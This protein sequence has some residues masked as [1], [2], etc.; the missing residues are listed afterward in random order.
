MPPVVARDAEVF[1]GASPA[2]H[3]YERFALPKG[4][5]R[6][7][8]TGPGVRGQDC[9][10]PVRVIGN[11]KGRDVAAQRPFG[12]FLGCERQSA[13]LRVQSI[14]TDE[15]IKPLQLAVRKANRYATAILFDIPD[16][17]AE[18]DRNAI[19]R[20][21]YRRG[22]VVPGNAEQTTSKISANRSI[23]PMRSATS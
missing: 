1:P 21:Q 16:G 22:N 13:H 7:V 5:A 9:L 10:F 20:C 8:S 23:S 15:E 12:L 17:G 18:M 2:H 19:A 3:Q 6:D 4:N 11:P 14:G